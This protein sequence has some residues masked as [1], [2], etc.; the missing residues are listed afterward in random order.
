MFSKST[1]YQIPRQRRMRAGGGDVSLAAANVSPNAKVRS[2]SPY[3]GQKD[4]SLSSDFCKS[5]AVAF[6]EFPS[7]SPNYKI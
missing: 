7:L 5:S 2:L 6:P 4:G 1:S 3:N